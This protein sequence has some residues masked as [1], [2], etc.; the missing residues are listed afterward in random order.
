MKYKKSILY[1]LFIFVLVASIACQQKLDSLVGKGLLEPNNNTKVQDTILEVWTLSDNLFPENDTMHVFPGTDFFPIGYYD[2]Q[3]FGSTASSIYLQ[4]KPAFYPFV[5][6]TKNIVIDSV[7][8]GLKVAYVWGDTVIKNTVKYIVNEITGTNFTLTNLS[9]FYNILSNQRS[10]TTGTNNLNISPN[11]I[12]IRNRFDSF[13][14]YGEAVVGQYRMK[15][16]NAL[17]QGL[18]NAYSA[19]TTAFGS[20]EKWNNLFKGL[21]ISAEATLGNCLTYFS[22]V[23]TT[24]RLSVYY[25]DPAYPDSPFIAKFYYRADSSAYALSINKDRN[26]VFSNHYNSYQTQNNHQLFL[27]TQPGGYTLLQIP[28]LNDPA[29]KNIIV[30]Q[31][32]LLAEVDPTYYNLNP[33]G[34]Q[35]LPPTYIY[36]DIDTTATVGNFIPLLFDLNYVNSYN[37]FPSTG[38]DYNYFKGNYIDSAGKFMGYTMNISRTVQ[39]EIKQGKTSTYRLYAPVLLN[40]KDQ[41]TNYAYANTLVAGGRTVLVGNYKGKNKNPHRLR[42]HLVYTKIQ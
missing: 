20:D 19:D 32:I 24:T 21:K 8:L 6:Q 36:L 17:A 35:N 28:Q 42:L 38:I 14:S 37:F 31:A 40:Y 15:L 16:D 41:L 33:T 18:I 22:L 26:D 12:N 30:N 3:Y 11:P 13:Y 7:V 39:N 1:S 5:L 4:L 29:F 23:D 27:E 9:Q 34:N 25:H 10:I 2:D